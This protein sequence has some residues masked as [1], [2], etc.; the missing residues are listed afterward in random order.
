MEAE[1][2]IDRAESGTKRSR[3][4]YRVLFLGLPE[5]E[6]EWMSLRQLA[7]AGE[8]VE[9]Y[10]Q[11]KRL[12]TPEWP[13]PR[14]ARQPV[15]KPAEVPARLVRKSGRRTR[16]VEKVRYRRKREISKKREGDVGVYADVT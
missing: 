11:A 10:H 14:T 4:Q 2:I 5:D 8:L 12:P 9:P 3:R 1:R 15:P 6:D 7:R 16:P 13:A